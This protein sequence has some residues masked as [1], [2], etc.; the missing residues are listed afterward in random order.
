MFKKARKQMMGIMLGVA[1]LMTESTIM[2]AE[3]TEP[4]MLSGQ[5]IASVYSTNVS[6]AR[7]GL[8][9]STSGKATISAG[10]TGRA[11]ASKI[12]M[13]VK[14]QKYNSTTKKWNNVKIWNKDSSI[15]NISFSKTYSITSKGKYRC[16]MT[17][18]VSCNGTNETVTET[19]SNVTY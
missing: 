17:A 9:I 6:R 1:M 16:K 2:A 13:K 10:V 18:T 8:S 11:N 4:I 3:S 7:V 12:V 14:L 5:P 19:S 15:S